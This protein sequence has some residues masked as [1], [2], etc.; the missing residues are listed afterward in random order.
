MVQNVFN[1]ASG[2]PGIASGAWVSIAGTGLSSSTRVWGSS[3]FA[4][5]RLPTSLDGVHVTIDG[6]PAYV[7]Y[8]SPTQ[9]NVLA[10]AD[11]TMGPV[12]VQ[13]SNS[14]GSSNTIMASK[15]DVAPAFFAYSQNP[16]Y[17]VA[18]VGATLIAPNGLLGNNAFTRPISPG[19]VVTLYATGLGSTNPQYPDGQTISRPAQLSAPSSVL[20]GG[21]S[22]AV[23]F[24]GIVGAGLYQINATVPNVSGGDQPLAVVINGKQSAAV[25][26]PIAGS[27]AVSPV[28]ITATGNNDT[29]PFGGG[30]YC[31]YE[32]TM[33]N[34]QASIT[35]GSDGKSV[36]A[37]ASGVMSEA[38][39]NGCPYPLAQ[40]GLFQFSGSGSLYGS[41][42]NLQLYQDPN[43]SEGGTASI[44]GTITNNQFSGTLVIHRTDQAAPLNWTT[45]HTLNSAS[46]APSSV[47]ANSVINNKFGS[48]GPC[49]VPALQCAQSSF[50][51]GTSQLGLY[52][53][54]RNA[55]AN[56]TVR[57]QFL[58]PDGSVAEDTGK[59]SLGTS[60][61]PNENYWW[62][63]TVNLNITGTWHV[64]MLVNGVT[65]VLAPFQVTPASVSLGATVVHYGVVDGT[66]A[67]EDTFAQQSNQS[68]TQIGLTF[69]VLNLPA[70]SSYRLRYV[71]PDGTTALDTGVKNLNNPFYADETYW[72]TYAVNL[73]MNG[74]WALTLDV[75]GATV[76]SAKFFAGLSVPVPGGG[77]AVEYGVV[78][79]DFLPQY[80]FV[81]GSTQIGAWVEV[82]QL[83]ANS[84]YRMRFIRPDGSVATDSGT[85]SLS[86]SPQNDMSFTGSP[87]R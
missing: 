62:A 60:P 16:R 15:A 85:T 23:Q 80:S 61:V 65:T 47:I 1:A 9:V 28:T 2:A 46:A 74:R 22:A 75:N 12:Q 6:L 25:Y 31:S 67:D 39:P 37:S 20:I 59:S 35:V 57:M 51:L 34:V 7:Y 40:P 30:T 11:S 33:A 87:I 38:A 42:L 83:P 73:D 24:S 4:D 55:P 54:I 70:N 56:T 77:T 72:F 17:A 5:N 29:E 84:T 79:G 81:Q 21:V 19:E 10:P 27:S 82:I 52:Y 48:N 14:Q 13:V 18:E 36:T 71:R 41:S 32:V 64:E 26:L 44:S 66:F 63:W 78:N 43:N 69:H 53:Q 68:S 45:T 3:D 49:D 86:S 58:R 50:S 76:G 8:I